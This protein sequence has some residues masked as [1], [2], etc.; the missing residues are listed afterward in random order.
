MFK[1]LKF[2]SLGI[3]ALFM[4]SGS[5]VIAVGSVF[6]INVEYLG[7][8]PFDVLEYALTESLGLTFGAW[9]WIVGL[10]MI[11]LSYIIT[12]RLPKLGVFLEFFL[13]GAFIDLLILTEL[14][15]DTSN[16]I[17]AVFFMLFGIV[18]VSFGTA[19]YMSAKMGAGPTDWFS[20][21]VSEKWGISFG[22]M[23]IFT[24]GGAVLIGFLLS[25]PV[26]IGTL[27]FCLIY[28]PITDYFLQYLQKYKMI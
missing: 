27:V 10:F 25:G 20:L 11:F 18:L 7:L 1:D 14:I 24:E 23:S 4:I 8:H 5:F 28:G 3:R 2:V 15:P 9:H 6:M 26:Q 16:M 22:R 19:L 13:V 12:K 21:V 17:I